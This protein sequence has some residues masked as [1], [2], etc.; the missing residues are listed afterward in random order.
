MRISTS[1]LYAKGVNSMQQQWSQLLHTQQ[2]V[3]TGRRVLTPSDDPIA[4]AR[5]LEVGQSQSVNQQFLANQGHANDAMRLVETQLTNVNDI[6]QYARERA[7]EAGN[8]ALSGTEL[9]F[10]AEDMKSQFNALL[11]L[12][13]SQD[14]NGDYI[15][16]GYRAQTQPYTGDLAGVTYQGD[17][18]ERTVQVSAS[19][20]MPV[21]LPGSA[22]FDRT[23]TLDS[24]VTSV[25]GNG[26]NTG[27][28]TPSVTAVDPTAVRPGTRYQIRYSQPDPAIPGTYTVSRLGQDGE[29]VAWTSAELE[30]MWPPAGTPPAG[31]AVSA[32]NRSIDFTPSGLP[33][34]APLELDGLTIGLPDDPM[35]DPL[36]V[37]QDARTVK[38]E[39]GDGD[40][41][42]I[43]VPS[44][45]LLENVAMVAAAL[46][47][48]GAS[49]AAGV[50]AFA[51]TTLDAGHE[52]ILKVRAQLGSQ[53]GEV[54][55]LQSLGSDL[56][57]HYAE[58][59]T[60]LVGLDSEGYA[61]AISQLTQQQM[62]L[63]AAQQSYMRISGLSLF[64]YM[65]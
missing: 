19:R 49:G 65:G 15:F 35:P 25:V 62:F 48:P 22:V 56:D 43:F 9:S 32:D 38:D 1:M 59:I 27:S 4:S 2:Q 21:S 58:I 45:N 64:N 40:R 50:V 47:S 31:Y 41:F 53:M 5:A 26:H 23:L 57:G 54:E 51:L 63:Q 34:Y 44:T 13:N 55:Q 8:G 46:D 36:D 24:T 7:V 61:A 60:G 30:A 42:E 39:V 17:Q 11:A 18:G 28:E 16:G 20:Y 12:A 10:L 6:L 52:N 14:G 3:A 33:P 37:P 29:P